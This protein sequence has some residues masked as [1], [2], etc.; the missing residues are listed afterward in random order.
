[1]LRKEIYMNK[2]EK[3]IL[4]EL[5]ER[6]DELIRFCRLHRI[7]V[8]ICTEPNGTISSTVRS[9]RYIT[10]GDLSL[11]MSDDNVT[12]LALMGNQNLRLSPIKPYQNEQ[13]QMT[14]DALSDFLGDD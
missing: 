13:K 8:Y 6:T 3:T 12:K 14:D 1:M 9:I 11:C 7:P 4:S 10:P 5:S 2:Q